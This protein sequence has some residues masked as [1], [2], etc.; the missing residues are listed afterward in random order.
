MGG[1]GRSVK[2][3]KDGA[4][5]LQRGGGGGWCRGENGLSGGKGGKGLVDGGH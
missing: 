3:W 1:M 4:N 5:L 2:T